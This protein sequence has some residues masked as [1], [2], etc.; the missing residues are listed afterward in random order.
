MDVS[1]E[2]EAEE[3]NPVEEAE[4]DEEA[5]EEESAGD[6][7]ETEEEAEEE[8]EDPSEAPTE[9]EGGAGG[10]TESDRANG[11]VR[12]CCKRARRVLESEGV[13]A[14]AIRKQKSCGERQ[15]LRNNL[16]LP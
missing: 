8:V 14:E 3:G 2:E 13:E 15:L 12:T 11:E 6:G 10:P 5:S 7:T 16:I 9:T 1:T 4:E